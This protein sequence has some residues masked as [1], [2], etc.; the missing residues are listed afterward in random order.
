MFG[1]GLAYVYF[2]VPMMVILITPALEG[3][4]P[5]WQEAA[6]SLGAS[7][8]DYMRHVAIPVLAP[9][10]IGAM[11]I[12]FGNAF[13]AYATALALV[14]AAIPLVP[15]A[16]NEAINGNVLVNQD[17]IA[18]ALGVEMIVVVMI[19]MV[20]YWLVQRRARRWLQ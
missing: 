12:L 8:S 1:V 10:F 17:R 13:S 18:L 11:L 19:I 2:Q 16:I 9:A 4:R 3:L 20:G 7:R 5:Q 6:E 14:G 15:A